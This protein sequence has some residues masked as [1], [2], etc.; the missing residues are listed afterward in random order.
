MNETKRLKREIEDL[1]RE[2]ERKREDLAE[3]DKPVA[4]PAG[5]AEHEEEPGDGDPNKDFS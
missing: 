3:L 4:D 1:E 5:E 2:T